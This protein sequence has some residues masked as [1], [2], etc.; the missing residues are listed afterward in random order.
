MRLQRAEHPWHSR[1]LTNVFESGVG[2]KVRSD[3]QGVIAR[4]G[5]K[6]QSLLYRIY[7]LLNRQKKAPW[8]RHQSLAYHQKGRCAWEGCVG[9]KKSK[10]KVPRSHQTCMRCEECSA[11]R[12]KNVFFCNDTKKGVPVLCHIAYHNKYHNKKYNSTK[13]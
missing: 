9:K 11:L 10:A 13:S 4:S 6:P 1:D 2:R 7:A 8:R 3:A 12:N 5:R